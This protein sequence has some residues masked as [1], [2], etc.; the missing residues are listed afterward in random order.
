MLALIAMLSSPC[1]RAPAAPP[2]ANAPARQLLLHQPP[3]RQ[4]LRRLHADCGQ[5]RAAAPN[6][7]VIPIVLARQLRDDP[8]PLSLLDLPPK[9]LGVAGAKLAITDNNTTGRFMNQEFKLE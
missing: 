3:L 9:D 4:S 6:H 1:A 8:L 7:V 2:A 5:S